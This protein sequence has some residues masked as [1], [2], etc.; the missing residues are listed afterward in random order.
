MTIKIPKVQQERHGKTCSDGP[1][2]VA[3]SMWVYYKSVHCGGNDSSVWP[4]PIWSRGRLAVHSAMTLVAWNFA[5]KPWKTKGFK[6]SGPE[7]S[8]AMVTSLILLAHLESRQMCSKTKQTMM[9]N[10]PWMKVHG[11]SIYKESGLGDDGM[12]TGTWAYLHVGAILQW[13]TNSIECQQKCNTT[14]NA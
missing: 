12:T 9:D 6:V 5:K 4:L 13:N 10:E 14:T 7:K 3:M 1:C 2:S 8:W 11:M